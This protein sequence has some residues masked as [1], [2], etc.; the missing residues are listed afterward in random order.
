MADAPTGNVEV[1]FDEAS[2]RFEARLADTD[3]V[4]FLEV[5]PGDKI[6]TLVHTEVPASFRGRGVGSQLVKAALSHVRG[7]GLTV[8]P[9][10]PFVLDYLRENPAE[11]DVVNPRYAHLLE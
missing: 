11:V 2:N 6:W 5:V 10:C 4:A 9:I 3:D 7:A 1:H 8:R